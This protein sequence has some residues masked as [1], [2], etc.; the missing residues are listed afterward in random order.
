MSFLALLSILM[1]LAPPLAV[2]Q[3]GNSV[4]EGSVTQMG[5]GQ[6]LP[7][8]RVTLYA[9]GP[10][11]E[12][13]TDER[14]H[15]AF[16]GISPGR[17]NVS[18]QREGYLGTSAD[19]AFQMSVSAQVNVDERQPNT[20]LTLSLALGGVISGRLLDPAGRPLANI[21]V[22]V[23]TQNSRDRRTAL[24]NDRGEY[25]FAGLAPERYVVAASPPSGPNASVRD[26]YVRTYYPGAI[27]SNR[28]VPVIVALGSEIPGVDFTIQTSVVINVSGK[29][30]LDLPDVRFPY[31]APGVVPQLVVYSFDPDPMNTQFI[32]NTGRALDI[33][34]GHFQIRGV[35]PG[36]YELVAVIPGAGSAYIGQTRIDAGYQDMKDVTIVVRPG[37]DVPVQVIANAGSTATAVQNVGLRIKDSPKSIGIAGARGGSERFS[38]QHVPPGE[39]EISVT[40][41]QGTRVADI[42]QAGR[43]V[44]KE[45]IVVG[46]GPPEPLYLI[47]ERVRP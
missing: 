40:T 19:G 37:V 21:S 4:I 35:R 41:S 11:G 22:E 14:G 10:I 17:Y 2:P 13:T 29:V 15:F 9:P 36:R 38:I 45:G 42:Q 20:S 34:D 26:T 7:G 43:S 12:T 44:F 28:A 8:V 6:P 46:D 25:R 24:T 1:V 16:G 32:R 5:P 18:A 30:I 39:Y 27:E 33:N 47:L 31:T 23:L 3:R